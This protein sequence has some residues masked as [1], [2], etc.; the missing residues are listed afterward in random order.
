M[1]LPPIARLDATLRAAS[2]P[3]D[4][5]SGSQ[6]NVRVDYQASATA[7]NRTDGAAIVAAFD[8]SA[9]ADTT[10]DAQRAKAAAQA[11]IDNGQLQVGDT[12]SRQTVGVVL[13]I[14]DAINTLRAAIP[15]PIVSITRAGTVA[16]VTTRVPHG[17]V[18]GNPVCITGTTL[19]AYNIATTV[20]TAPTPT[21]FT[22]PVA[23]SPATPAVGS[24]SWTEAEVPALAAI[25]VAQV[26]AA[27]K[28]K[29]AATAE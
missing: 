18:A 19:A 13:A 14:L 10:F 6:G 17:R 5:V 2:I 11:A 28:A 1:T 4:G 20:A 27:V 25:T 8:W 7:Q 24:M 15:H 3:I 12:V 9:A 16:T 26:V 23:G 22:Y 21:T 29:I